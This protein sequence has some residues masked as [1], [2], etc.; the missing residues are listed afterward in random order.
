M[1]RL[2]RSIQRQPAL[3]AAAGLVILNIIAL[4][5]VL[6]LSGAAIGGINAGVAAVLA[7]LVGLVASW[8]LSHVRR[9]YM[10]AAREAP[11]A[12]VPTADSWIGHVVG[13]DDLC[14][15]MIKDIRDPATR[16][17]HIIIGSE[18]AGKTAVLVRLTKLLA[19]G[20]KIPLSVRIRDA[21]GGR[22]FRGVTNGKVP[23]PVRLS[24]AQ[25]DLDFN[26][27]AR[28]KF[29]TD[30][31]A[32]LLSAADGE[33][34]WRQL[35]QDDKVVVL[36]DGLEEALIEGT[37]AEA[38]DD[39]IRLAVRRAH[40]QRLPL[41]VASRPHDPIRGLDVAIVELGPLSEDAAIEYV[42]HEGPG[43]DQYRLDWIVETASI[44]QNPFYL[45]IMRQ[46]NRAQRIQR[47]SANRYQRQLDTRGADRSELRLRLLQIW[48]A[49]LVSGHF[50]PGVELS[51]FDRVATIEQ[52]SV[53][54][55]IGLRHDRLQVELNELT[56]LVDYV[57]PERPI[58][59]TARERLNAIATPFFDVRLAA[60]RGTQLQL[61]EARGGA[62]RFPHGILQAYLGS[63]LLAAAMAD[64]DFRA[65]ALKNA[66]RELLIALVMHS[67]ATKKQVGA[68]G[69][70]DTAIDI[71]GSSAEPIDLR[72]LLRMAAPQ[73]SD[74]KALELY[75]TAL[76][77]D[78]VDPAPEHQAI[79]MEIAKHW[80]NVAERDP[81]TLEHAKLDLVRRFGEAARALTE[82]G[83]VY[84]R[85]ADSVRPAYRQLFDIGCRELSYPVRLAAAQE[86]GAGGDAALDDLA[87]LLGPDEQQD[88]GETDHRTAEHYLDEEGGLTRRRLSFCAWLV[89]MLVGSAT[90]RCSAD[91]RHLL[92]QWLEF[93][94]EQHRTGRVRFAL[95]LEIALAQGFKY[96]AN[97]RDADP[98]TCPYLIA[99]AREM[100]K[101]TTFWFSRLTLV[102]ALCLAS[103]SDS[104]DRRS[105]DREKDLDYGELVAF[106]LGSLVARQEH[107]F[108]AEACWLATQA[109]KT[110]QPERYIWIDEGGIVT[111]V[112]SRSPSLGL[113]RKH[114]LWI[115]PS[116]GWAFLHPRAQQL[117]AD[118]ILLLNLAS[119]N[120][121]GDRD[122][123]LQRIDRND[124]PP[125]L[126]RDPSPLD[127]TR[128]IGM[129]APSEP[130][131]NCRQACPFELCAYPAKGVLRTE[132]SQAFCR[133]QQELVSGIRTGN[134]TAAPWR[135]ASPADLRRFWKHM[136]QRG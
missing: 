64:A 99:Q 48:E 29:L 51:R 111:S 34:V 32:A 121:F 130:G 97:R 66:G 46:L 95:S 26:E 113:R 74:A 83:M 82:R 2:W 89:P 116:S 33:K 7:F 75:A 102:H 69:R 98:A 50:P 120:E 93:I 71:S 17:P 136:S 49:A 35:R 42:L 88:S 11:G 91:A 18:G 122:R 115:P 128:S 39:L 15:A 5:G 20:D 53:L 104:A 38:R 119:R 56:A 9:G 117:V 80:Q 43:E 24:D 127:P 16:R 101:V 112:G 22:G 131:A 129:A 108:V 90:P 105:A 8:Q 72:K 110:G 30:T 12:V 63:R 65:E 126:V 59:Q 100:L 36:A 57:E 107:P 106:W 1:R 132:L 109:L 84:G 86:I 79:A 61:V 123:W 23:I 134:S 41:I 45:Q 77:I 52:L 85:T 92:E 81:R 27:L 94:R 87:A 47:P 103:L 4:S 13:R 58:I 25:A 67:R 10:R 135:R 44:P 19:E 21:L 114:S 73:R 125:C 40:A 68:R 62:V 70:T 14:Y 96:A 37:A 133:R 124:L 55:C 78:S 60:T 54:A 28:M 6:H 76:E 31:D 118:V 3:F